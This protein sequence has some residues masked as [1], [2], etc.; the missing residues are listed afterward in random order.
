[1]WYIIEPDQVQ[2]FQKRVKQVYDLDIYKEEGKWFGDIEFC[3]RNKIRL[4]YFVQEPG[5]I[6]NFLFND[7]NKEIKL[8]LGPGCLSWCKSL[9]ITMVTCWNI[10][11]QDKVQFEK[12]FERFEINRQIGFKVSF[13]S[14]NQGVIKI[15]YYSY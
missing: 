9:G 1:V 2:E 11:S 13:Y 6:V 15:E 4:H 8:I 14:K 10:C 3:L 7:Y 5:D 12:A